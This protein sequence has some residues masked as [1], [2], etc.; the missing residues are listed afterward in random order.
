VLSQFLTLSQLLF[1][2][3]T[4]TSNGRLDNTIQSPFFADEK[5][6]R[7]AIQNTQLPPFSLAPSFPKHLL[8]ERVIPTPFLLPSPRSLGTDETLILS[9]YSRR[10]ARGWTSRV[11]SVEW[12][13]RLSSGFEVLPI[14]REPSLIRTWWCC[15][16]RCRPHYT[17]TTQHK[18][19]DL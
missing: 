4:V 16:S 13:A 12:I 18:R 3:R 6:V 10:S 15:R 8:L 14:E 11:R 5:Y 1:L 17:L 19:D 9:L 7:D 2:T